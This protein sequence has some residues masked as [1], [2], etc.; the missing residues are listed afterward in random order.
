MGEYRKNKPTFWGVSPARV[1]PL[2]ATLLPLLP[3]PGGGAYPGP[4]WWPPAD[5]FPPPPA[6]HPVAHTLPPAGPPARSRPAAAALASSHRPL[7]LRA[8]GRATG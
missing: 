6:A 2:P 1:R 7:A 5:P 4:R 3:A 8:G